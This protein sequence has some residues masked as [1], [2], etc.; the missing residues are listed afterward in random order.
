[1]ALLRLFSLLFLILSSSCIFGVNA[2]NT[3]AQCE[4]GE[5][6]CEHNNGEILG[7]QEALVAL[8]SEVNSLKNHLEIQTEELENLLE[9]QTHL[10][11]ETQ[12]LRAKMTSSYVAWGQA[13]CPLTATTVYKGRNF[14]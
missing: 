9:T 7:L 3:R 12:E 14:I 10:E 11:T 2:Q 8:Q 1:M 13:D 5:N 4:N 6:S